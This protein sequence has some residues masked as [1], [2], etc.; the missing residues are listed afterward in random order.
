MKY[1]IRCGVNSS[2]FVEAMGL[3]YMNKC[4]ISM[5]LLQLVVEGDSKL[6]IEVAGGWNIIRWK[7]STIISDINILI[8]RLHMIFPFNIFT[9]KRN[10]GQI[11][12]PCMNRLPWI[13][14]KAYWIH[15]KP[16]C[17]F[18]KVDSMGLVH[19]MCLC[20][21]CS[22]H[23]RMTIFWTGEKALLNLNGVVK[24][25]INLS[26]ISYFIFFQTI[27]VTSKK[28]YKGIMLIRKGWAY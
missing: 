19:L 3:F 23:F 27:Y 28:G 2:N 12:F 17:G 25:M 26:H 5:G 9:M 14:K 11:L 20:Q 18:I 24:I 22:G 8:G 15:L 21:H 6:I 16:L 13:W 7:V 10:R 1:M 4:T